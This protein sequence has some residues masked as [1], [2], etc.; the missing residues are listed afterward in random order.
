MKIK[1]FCSTLCFIM[2]SFLSA[3]YNEIEK[4]FQLAL[5]YKQEG[6]MEQDEYI[7]FIRPYMREAKKTLKAVQYCI[8]NFDSQA[9]RRY[10]M[11]L[12]DYNVSCFH[13]YIRSN[14]LSLVISDKAKK[15]AK[16]NL[17]KCTAQLLSAIKEIKKEAQFETLNIQKEL[18]KTTKLFEKANAK[19]YKKLSIKFKLSYPFAYNFN[20][21]L[22]D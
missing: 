10:M 21:R 16:E 11:C 17:K 7:K 12:L 5:Y 9:S 6:L 20:I 8:E 22:S 3:S 15:I 14:P 18:T 19:Y 13:N 4:E 2:V 1:L